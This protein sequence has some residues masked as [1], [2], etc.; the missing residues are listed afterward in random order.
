MKSASLRPAALCGLALLALTPIARAA[1]AAAQAPYDVALAAVPVQPVVVT[2]T[3]IAQPVSS[4][5][6]DVRVIDAEQIRNAAG[7]TLPELLQAQAGLEI[8]GNGGPGQL[9]NVF[10]RGTNANHVVVLVD[11]VRI[12]SASAGTTSLQHLPLSQIERIEVL[13]GPAS[14]LYGAD[15][16]GGVIQVFTRQGE[17]T[18]AR[19]AVGSDRTREVAA[20]FGRRL[21]DTMLSLDAGYK[22]TDGFSATNPSIDPP[23]TPAAWQLFN[24][25]RDASRNRNVSAGVTHAWAKDQTLALRAWA[26]DTDTHFDNGPA[27][28][29]IAHQRLSGMS[30]ESRN[31]LGANWLSLLRLARGTDDYRNEG[32]DPSRLRTDQ[33]QF[34]WQNDFALP[35]GTLAAGL[36][37]RRERVEGDTAAYLQTGRTI[38]SVFG[39]YAATFGAHGLEASLRHDDNSQFGGHDTGR[40]AYGF[41]LSPTW[42][43]S[44]AAGTAFKAPTF[45]DLYLQLPSFQYAGNPDLR[46]ERARS[47]ET[48]L[49]YDDGGRRAGLTLFRN[50]VKDL[51]QFVSDPVTF[52]S[53]VVNVGQARIRGATLDAGHVTALWNTRAEWTLQNAEDADTGRRLARRAKQYGSF[54]FNWTPGPWRAGLELVASGDRFSDAGNTMRLGGYTLLNLHA[55]YALTP[56]LSLTARVSN[57]TDKDYTLSQGFNTPGRKFFVALEYAAK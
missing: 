16:I 36:E 19:L 41:Q 1:E 35:V 55:G 34:T 53:T 21:G 46:P 47:I 20:G 42:R 26:S 52:D 17:R 4:A 2:A 43:V 13:R 56:E 8:A 31:R 38:R 27:T 49:R 50:K 39:S 25:D 28:D 44:A 45:N 32:Q 18:T 15:A 7:M 48:A 24:A 6:A 51:I 54:S 37:W 30:A 10:V 5:L 9:T 14:S 11:G 23:G 3:R 57:V 40:L 29:D 33:D 12:N 22:D